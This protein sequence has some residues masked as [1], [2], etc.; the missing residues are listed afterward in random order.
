MGSVTPYRRG[1]V[2]SRLSCS[3]LS[4]MA[5]AEPAMYI[6]EDRVVVGAWDGLFDSPVGF[7]VLQLGAT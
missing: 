4:W 1:T 2:S 3:S 5:V 6:Q 7:K